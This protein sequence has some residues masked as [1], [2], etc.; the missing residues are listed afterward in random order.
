VPRLRQNIVTDDWV[1]IAPERSKRPQDF[2]FAT[3]PKK[4][5]KKDCPFCL[6]ADDAYRFSIKEAETENVY[7]IPNKYPAFVFEDEVTQKEGDYYPSYKSL[8]GHEV[9]ILKDH[10]KELAD[11]KRGVLEEYYYVYQNRINHYRNNPTIEYAMVIHNYGPEAAASIIHPHSQIFASSI[12]PPLIEKEIVGSQRFFKEKKQCVFC[13]LVEQEQEKSVRVIA[14]NRYFLAFT[15]WAARFPFESWIIPKSH[16]P[17]F[18]KI[19]RTERLA[20]AEVFSI[21]L[22]KLNRSLNNPPFN[23][24]IHTTPPRMEGKGRIEEYYHWHM[25]IIPRVSKFGGYELGSG[26]V[27][28]VVLPER[29]AKFLNRSPSP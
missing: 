26:L 18:E 11:L 24:F 9:I 10:D 23:Y 8:G 2:A 25:E 20:L 12:I 1:V 7:V 19:N 22:K 5:S 15:F 27:I 29:A 13:W 17:Y 21:V 6:E 16:Q 4:A 28:D 3:S 14:E